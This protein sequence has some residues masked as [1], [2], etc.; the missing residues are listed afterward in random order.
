[1]EVINKLVLVP[2]LLS[3]SSTTSNGP[4]TQKLHLLDTRFFDQLFEALIINKYLE[5]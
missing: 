3:T 1:M 5:R 4:E 2:E